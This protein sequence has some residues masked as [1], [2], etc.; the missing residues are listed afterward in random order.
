MEI[1]ETQFKAWEKTVDVQMHFNDLCLRLRSYGISILGVLLG[2]AAIAYRYAGIV[3]VYCFK[4]HTSAIFLVIS[5]IVWLAF[6]IMDRFWY[7]EL[8]RG[9][10]QHG[11]RLEV[12]LKDAVP[13]I[14][15]A[16]SIRNA[17]HSSLNI[18][19]AKKLNIFYLSILFVQL[20]GLAV[21]L[22]GAVRVATS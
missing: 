13:D 5:I 7:H 14:G 11:R 19:A 8:L 12:A 15:L 2:A 18:N 1:N 20:I 16:Q 10:V 3:E 4:I 9:A 17:S 21:L 22:S 6:Y